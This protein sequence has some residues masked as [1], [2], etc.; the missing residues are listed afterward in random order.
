LEPDQVPAITPASPT[1]G[2]MISGINTRFD[3]WSPEFG[4]WLEKRISILQGF[5]TP[6]GVVTRHT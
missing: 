3:D 4:W 5:A 6:T 1:I 2:R